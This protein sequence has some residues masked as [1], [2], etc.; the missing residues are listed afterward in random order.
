[1]SQMRVFYLVSTTL[2]HNHSLQQAADQNLHFE[3]HLE[4]FAAIRL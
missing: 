2:V 3:E 1:M 4:Q